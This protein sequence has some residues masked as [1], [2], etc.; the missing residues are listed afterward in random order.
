M[1]LVR[2]QGPDGNVTGQ[3]A[4]VRAEAAGTVAQCSEWRVALRGGNKNG[5]GEAGFSRG[6]TIWSEFQAE[7]QEQNL[8][9]RL[10]PKWSE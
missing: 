2:A 5:P 10:G 3:E 4:S 9:Q 7:A 8:D 1:A 6:Q